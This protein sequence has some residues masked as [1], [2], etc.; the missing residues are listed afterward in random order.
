LATF[1]NLIIKDML[2]SFRGGKIHY[3]DSGSGKVIVLIHGY[4]ETSEVWEEYSRKLSQN[5][6]VLRV[7]LPGHGLSDIV[8]ST[9]TMELLA[10]AI[11][12]LLDLLTV[13]KA[14]IAGHSM[15]G[16]ATLAFLQMFPEYLSG[17]S[18][19]H[20]HPL[21]DAPEAIEKRKQNIRIVEEGGKENMIPDFIRGLYA[22][23]N[24]EKCKAALDR[25]ILI[26]SGTNEKTIIADLK[27]MM[28]R[29]SRVTVVEEGKVPFLWILGTMDNH[30]NYES[31]QERVKL[32]GNA[33][34][35][36]LNNS[37][38]MGF[39][40]EEEASVNVITD[41]VNSI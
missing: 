35:V 16:Y 5:F 18:L 28:A 30:I 6:R 34:V 25:S 7:D 37:G 27:G 9:N 11:K 29:P 4:L 36:I 17:Y 38:H 31:I 41:F 23:T 33:K 13:K 39:I 1:T 26:A 10:E 14:F 19:F 32:P 22:G 3:Y 24:Y 20:S 15:G 40:E 12:E 21:G 8:D 2:F